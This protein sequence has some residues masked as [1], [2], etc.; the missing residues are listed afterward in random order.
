MIK[1]AREKVEQSKVKNIYFQIGNSLSLPFIHNSF[2]VVSCV[3]FFSSFPKHMWYSIVQEM[4]RVLKPGGIV[5]IH[6]QNL[7][8]GIFQRAVEG[9]RKFHLYPLEDRR[10]FSNHNIVKKIGIYL[11]FTYFCSKGK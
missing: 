3:A 11:P 4:Y 1:I 7:L 5:I 9:K 8:H 2:D 10:L 6:I